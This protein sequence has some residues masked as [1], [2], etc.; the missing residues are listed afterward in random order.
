VSI[1]ERKISAQKP[2]TKF[3]GQRRFILS[4]GTEGREKETRIE[5][6]DKDLKNKGKKA[7]IFVLNEKGLPLN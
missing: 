5:E 6:D 4:K 3:S 7:S 2:K 1:A